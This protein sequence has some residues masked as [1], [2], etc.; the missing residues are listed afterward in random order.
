MSSSAHH[1]P[2]AAAGAGA[3]CHARLA[4][5]EAELI[6][7]RANDRRLTEENS[8]LKARNTV[9]QKP[10]SPKAKP[11]ALNPKPYALSVNL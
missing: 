11:S 5:A 6:F 7:L 2:E 10:L 1:P 4:D 8:C 9:P 3:G